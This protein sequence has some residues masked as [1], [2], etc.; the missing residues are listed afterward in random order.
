[1]AQNNSNAASYRNSGG[2]RS[3]GASRHLFISPSSLAAAKQ[4]SAQKRSVMRTRRS[5]VTVSVKGA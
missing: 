4:L 3:F 1:M 2:G 5:H